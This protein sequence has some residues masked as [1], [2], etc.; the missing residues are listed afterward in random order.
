MVDIEK[1]GLAII[2]LDSE[3]RR[4]QSKS[5]AAQLRVKSQMNLK[6]R[7]KAVTLKC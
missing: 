5:G 6:S 4:G 3:D 7:Q 1:L 2:R